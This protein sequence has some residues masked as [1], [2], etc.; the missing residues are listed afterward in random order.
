LMRFTFSDCFETCEQNGNSTVTIQ[1]IQLITN[2]N[3]TKLTI[4]QTTNN[5]TIFS[6]K[7]LRRYA[8]EELKQ[9]NS[10]RLLGYSN[11]KNSMKNCE[12][13]SEKETQQ[14]QTNNQLLELCSNGSI[15]FLLGFTEHPSQMMGPLA[16]I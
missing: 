13:S 9:Y 1:K 11:R 10:F 8:I 3:V 7:L 2:Y 15:R 16:G 14:T 4:S 5:V 6:R 12:F